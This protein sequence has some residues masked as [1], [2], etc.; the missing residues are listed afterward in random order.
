MRAMS[1]GIS[2][3]GRHWLRCSAFSPSS[4][5]HSATCRSV[6]T[7]PGDTVLMRMRSLPSSTARPRVRPFTD[8]LAIA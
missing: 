1:S 3:S 4:S 6:I 8:D 2:L 5:S 7:Q